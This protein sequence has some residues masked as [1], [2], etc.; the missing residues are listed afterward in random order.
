MAEHLCPTLAEEQEQME[1]QRGYKTDSICYPEEAVTRF[2]S[3][4]TPVSDS[5][6]D[7]CKKDFS[8]YQYNK[9]RWKFNKRVKKALA[10]LDR[11]QVSMH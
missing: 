2:Y 6:Y 8:E 5:V 9:H 4:F 11:A 10:N 7:R 3:D 1:I